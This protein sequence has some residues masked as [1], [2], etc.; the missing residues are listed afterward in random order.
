MIHAYLT[1]DAFLYSGTGVPEQHI[2]YTQKGVC[3]ADATLMSYFNTQDSLIDPR[4]SSGQNTRLLVANRRAVG[5]LK[6]YFDLQQ[7]VASVDNLS[8]VRILPTDN[9]SQK[10]AKNAILKRLFNVIECIYMSKDGTYQVASNAINNTLLGTPT[11]YSGYVASSLVCSSG[12]T[13]A[14][15]NTTTGYTGP[16][17]FYDTFSFKFN[18]DSTKPTTFVEF[19]I[20]LNANKFKAEYPFSS[21]VKVVYPC[22]PSSMVQPVVKDSRG[23]I[24]STLA[25]YAT[26]GNIVV[27]AYRNAQLTEATNAYAHTGIA[28]Y[29]TAYKHGELSGSYHM[30]F[31]LL[32]RGSPPT[33]LAMR[34]AIRNS[35]FS[36]RKTGTSNL[37]ATEAEW[38]LIFPNLFINGGYYL[39]PM[40]FNRINYPARVT[41]DRN[42]INYQRI[43]N[44]LQSLFTNIINISSIMN[45]LEIL[46][47]PGSGLYILAFPLSDNNST[48]QS[49][50][51][52]HPTYQAINALSSKQGYY[53]MATHTQEFNKL[54]AKCIKAALG[55]ITDTSFTTEKINGRDYLVFVN[56]AIEYHMLTLAGARGG[57]YLTD[58]DGYGNETECTHE[59]GYSH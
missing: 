41:I 37:L 3:V 54:M 27:P 44:T 22:E 42:I 40:Y 15:Y 25:D 2:Q 35:L 23:N 31:T 39:I 7:V 24:L 48:Y 21:I 43:S 30:S 17:A 57:M 8:P 28:Q 47:A 14:V 46:Q 45:K 58:N 12:T 11:L 18:L 32:Y 5:A 59:H 16:L 13:M 56:N 10:D 51:K 19:K 26:S 33:S 9:Q 49:V 53:G 4:Y 20:W 36:E 52:E 1:D 34:E 50:A 29:V 55:M 38:K 6:L